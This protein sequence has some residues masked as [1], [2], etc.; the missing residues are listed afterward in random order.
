MR[1]PL[2]RSKDRQRSP[3]P[4]ICEKLI[5]KKVPSFSDAP[6]GQLQYNNSKDRFQARNK[7]AVKDLGKIMDA[8]DNEADAAFKAGSS[9]WDLVF[10]QMAAA[11]TRNEERSDLGSKATKAHDENRN[12]IAE[13]FETVPDSILTINMAF[14]LLDPD[15][16]DMKVQTEAVSMLLEDLPALIKILL[17]EEKCKNSVHGIAKSSGF[18]HL[19]SQR[20]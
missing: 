10:E 4:Q 8:H 14:D 13:T 12:K 18:F 19:A 20:P 1:R 6:P 15:P 17:G 2:W 9:S 16:A 11:K 7:V 5:R 3:S